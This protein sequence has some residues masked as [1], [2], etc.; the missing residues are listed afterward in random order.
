MNGQHTRGPWAFRQI[1]N[2][3]LGYIEADGC[4]IMHAGVTYRPAA[5]NI[6]N[7]NLIAA[8]PDLFEAL[9][10]LIADCGEVSMDGYV[11]NSIH[12]DDVAKARAAIAKATGA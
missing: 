8:A 12:S 6:A 3:G 9:E 10:A 11:D 2:D 7:A 1:D 5:E 4:D